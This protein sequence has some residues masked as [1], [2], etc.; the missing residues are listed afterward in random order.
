MT[1]VSIIPSLT[2][3]LVSFQCLFL[4]VYARITLTHRLSSI[5]VFP[6]DY[7][8]YTGI[9]FE[10]GLFKHFLAALIENAPEIA[11]FATSYP[12]IRA[13][14]VG[15]PTY[16]NG[17]ICEFKSAAVTTS[18]FR[19]TTNCV[20]SRSDGS[21][22]VGLE[23]QSKFADKT[24]ASP[25]NLYI[26]NIFSRT[27][28]QSNLLSM[29]EAD[30]IATFD[31]LVSHLLSPEAIDMIMNTAY[32]TYLSAPNSYRFDGVNMENRCFKLVREI[33][34]FNP[35][36]FNAN[37]KHMCL[38]DSSFYVGD[39]VRVVCSSLEKLP[40][41]GYSANTM[42]SPSC[43][44]DGQNDS[45]KKAIG[46]STCYQ[47]IY[48]LVTR[49]WSVES[50]I[51]P[52]V[53]IDG[54]V[55]IE[56]PT[57][58][59]LQAQNNS[60][61]HASPGNFCYVFAGLKITVPISDPAVCTSITRC[62]ALLR[63]LLLPHIDDS[64]P[65]VD[66]TIDT[67][68]GTTARESSA[69][70]SLVYVV[71]VPVREPL[72]KN[73]AKR[74]STPADPN[75]KRDGK[76]SDDKTTLNDEG[77]AHT[78]ESFSSS[79][80]AVTLGTDALSSIPSLLKGFPCM[81][82]PSEPGSVPRA[83]SQGFTYVSISRFDNNFIKDSPQ[84]Q[85]KTA[86]S[87]LDE[88]K[89]S[90][91][92]P[93]IP[94]YDLHNPLLDQPECYI[95]GS[96]AGP[97]T[98]SYCSVAA[99]SF[100]DRH[101]EPTKTVSDTLL[102]NL[103]DSSYSH[104]DV[105]NL[106]SLLSG[107]AAE[108][109]SVIN[110]C[111]NK[112]VA[113]SDT[114]HTTHTLGRYGLV[115]PRDLL[116]FNAATLRSLEDE[117]ECIRP[118]DPTPATVDPAAPGSLAANDQLSNMSEAPENLCALM[119][120]ENVDVVHLN[121][122]GATV[123]S[124]QASGFACN[125]CISCSGQ[126][127]LASLIVRDSALSKTCITKKGSKQELDSVDILSCVYHC[128]ARGE[129]YV[130]PYCLSLYCHSCASRELLRSSAGKISY[131]DNILAMSGSHCTDGSATLTY[132]VRNLNTPCRRCVPAYCQN[133]QQVIEDPDDPLCAKYIE[134]LRTF[135]RT[136]L[137][138]INKKYHC[139]EY[140]SQNF[141]TYFEDTLK[142]VNSSLDF[143]KPN[144][145]PVE[146]HDIITCF[147][148]EENLFATSW[149]YAAKRFD[150][151][152][153]PHKKFRHSM[154]GLA[155]NASLV[156]VCGVPSGASC[157]YYLLVPSSTPPFLA[158]H[159]P[160][161]GQSSATG[162]QEPLALEAL[163]I[164]HNLPGF[165]TSAYVQAWLRIHPDL[166]NVYFH[167]A[168]AYT[169][170]YVTQYH[171]VRFSE[172]E[173]RRPLLNPAFLAATMQGLVDDAKPKS[174]SRQRRA[175]QPKTE[176]QHDEAKQK[177]TRSRKSQQQES[178]K[179]EEALQPATK[180]SHTAD[181][182]TLDQVCDK[183]AN[184]ATYT[185]MA[186]AAEVNRDGKQSSLELAMS[187]TACSP[188]T[189][190]HLLD[191]QN[192]GE[193]SC[194][195][196][197]LGAFSRKDDYSDEACQQRMP[198]SDTVSQSGTHVDC[199]GT[200]ALVPVTSASTLPEQPPEKVR[201]KRGPKKISNEQRVDFLNISETVG[202]VPKPLDIQAVLNPR[203]VALE[204]MKS[205]IGCLT[206]PVERQKDL[207]S[208]L[209]YTRTIDL[210]T[211]CAMG[212][213]Q[214]ISPEHPDGA[215]DTTVSQAL[216]DTKSF[217]LP[218]SLQ[219]ERMRAEVS[220]G[221]IALNGLNSALRSLINDYAL[222]ETQQIDNK[223]VDCFKNEKL[224]SQLRSFLYSQ[225]GEIPTGQELVQEVQRTFSEL[226][227]QTVPGFYGMTTDTAKR[228]EALNALWNGS[229]LRAFS[230]P[231]PSQTPSSEADGART[232]MEDAE[233]LLSS[234]D[235]LCSI[236][237]ECHGVL[238]IDAQAG[239]HTTGS[240]GG[241]APFPASSSMQRCLLT[242]RSLE[243]HAYF[244]TLQHLDGRSRRT[245]EEL[246]TSI[247]SIRRGII[248]L[249]RKQ[250]LLADE[251]AEGIL[252]K[253]RL[254]R[255]LYETTLTV[256]ELATALGSLKEN[257]ALEA[258]QNALRADLAYIHVLKEHIRARLLSMFRI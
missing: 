56:V 151:L 68:Q 119:F 166:A 167:G 153:S 177:R 165:L 58:S 40:S 211:G 83:T 173:S 235:T 170:E 178:I 240:T 139:R 216:L 44:A 59:V 219:I 169:P 63:C 217:C 174:N 204:S 201:R 62:T 126:V 228:L 11:D 29:K 75:A 61:T 210:A 156:E 221:S 205:W 33:D 3:Y 100:L 206:R 7:I 80:L 158:E 115:I 117:P 77:V 232:T 231:L 168:P 149:H 140:L 118:M 1:S 55:L 12:P 162:F 195:L 94:A 192:A 180:L 154:L 234:L 4:Q 212:A 226:P 209:S 245:C 131:L 84:P 86:S 241:P 127:S 142:V 69:D 47:I 91:T 250:A 15:V 238:N 65:T 23:V 224:I 135:S 225:H 79:N 81:T 18:M 252:E 97:N 98:S 96:L 258:E 21:S 189:R 215:I 247:D 43:Y 82:G 22:I 8:D 202:L 223:S 27:T 183:A 243:L 25:T 157:M 123:A 253:T 229:P 34:L 129:A 159:L 66:V 36:V 196:N 41:A 181:G 107:H 163:C 50:A 125:L 141:H 90:T 5:F 184:A 74:A 136:S 187:T 146:V 20:I 188:L 248:E 10:A 199:M 92:G 116:P 242:K 30:R 89:G 71:D 143:K 130:C 186:S 218:T 93:T 251:L 179:T 138:T 124:L 54:E 64:T 88:S 222:K 48:L 85:S 73:I 213:E 109:A 9:S 37:R 200:Q 150:W 45:S 145:Y 57:L 182:H 194:T 2:S 49:I 38:I 26:A 185:K 256:S 111:D 246:V 70:G 53:L 14:P 78:K 16:R 191:E 227:P 42:H 99:I 233:K 121:E 160:V 108:D 207:S 104:S 95:L 13:F 147:L 32:Q 76:D 17:D 254:E 155:S 28:H 112:I 220:N 6:L 239:S 52:H 101:F 103:C 237:Q 105:T 249:R 164:Q 102:T 190:K 35:N 171:A 39:V 175:P 214:P 197:T 113:S 137:S 161:V 133:L 110:S 120:H 46:S 176:G 255:S 257:S 114:Q 148:L 72:S 152:L 203:C 60:D 230:T 208:G 24:P 19:K 128:N 198:D 87:N 172:L 106:R 51:L 244:E 144:I 132:P 122:Y 236:E 31:L 134:K 67:S 193:T